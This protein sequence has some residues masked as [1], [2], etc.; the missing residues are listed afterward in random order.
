MAQP[1]VRYRLPMSETK[2]FELSPSV[3]VLLAGVI[4]AGAILLTHFFPAAATPAAEGVA[5]NTKPS[6]QQ[7]MGP[8]LYLQLAKQLGVNEA[9]YQSCVDTKKYQAKID[10]QA[11]E[12]QKVG[13]QG[14]PFTVALDTKTG[15][16]VAI[17]GALPYEQLKAAIA[18]INDKGTKI[19]ITAPSASDHIIGSPTAPIV[20]V[21]YSDFQCPYCQMIHPSLQKIVSE[22]NGQVAW[23]YRYFPLYQ[24]H[25]Q[26]EPSANAAECISEQLGN[27]AFWKF[28]NTLFEG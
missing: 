28:A 9:K 6:L 25:P 12:A 10:T 2:K 26:A 16:S 27:D 24:I 5:Q 23:A 18:S 4:I 17:S 21:E 20:L 3:S 22:S 8:A 7:Q 1:Q 13:G 19:A 11:A 15:K 14:T